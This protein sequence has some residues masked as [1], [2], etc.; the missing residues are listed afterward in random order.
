MMMSMKRYGIYPLLLLLLIGNKA[1][2]QE[3]LIPVG[4]IQPQL[5]SSSDDTISSVQVNEAE[6]DSIADIRKQFEK[7]NEDYSTPVLPDDNLQRIL[8]KDEPQ[9]SPEA[10]YW[11]HQ[12]QNSSVE[13]DDT[14]TFRDTMIVNPIFLPAVFKGD[15][16]PEDL[17]F[18]DTE[19]MT[20]KT[21]Y[22]ELQESDASLFED[23]ER[24][25]GFEKSAYA[26]V[27][28]NHPLYFRYSERD[29]PGE[30]V[31][32]VSIEKEIA[33]DELLEVEADASIEDVDSPDRY[34]PKRKY[35]VPYFESAI[36]FSQNH[37][38]DNWY[39]GGNSNLNLY[40]TNTFKYDYNKDKVQFSSELDI[41]MNIYTAPKDTLHDYQIGDDL[42]RI[43]GSFGY[44]AFNKWYYT[45][46][47]EFKTQ[48]F[49][50]Y[51][52]NEDVKQ[53][54]FLSPF[55]VTLGVGMKYDYKKEYNK[56]RD[57]ALSVNI[58]PLTY[59]YMYSKDEVDY[60]RHGFETDENGEYKNKLSQVGS[61]VRAEL[62]YNFNRNISW[63]SS[64]Y[65]FTAYSRMVGE[66]ENTLV[67]A[68]SRFFSTRI[69]L[70]IR[71]DDGVDRDSPDDSYFQ[72]N[73]VLSFGFNYKFQL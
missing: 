48:F 8:E 5:M 36:Q 22:D 44:E 39:N 72:L 50:S 29:M 71:Y 53:A 56:H 32:T 55:T 3:N 13:F 15:Y 11:A 17:T 31:E 23:V 62:T 57:L 45:F 66:F 70:H 9:I 60:S 42:F 28:N 64:L 12:A 35:W 63:E 59:T 27:R 2:S 26:Y 65:L 30:T 67:M 52:E 24:N 40:T 46:E 18:Y 25:K 6:L 43:Y 47:A 34:V 61:S 21:P 14:V 37:V 19:V 1:F 10:A 73:E 20:A 33:E 69:Y 54:A 16:L 68:I 4:V 38:S 41:N 51:E 7:Q 58:A 49:T